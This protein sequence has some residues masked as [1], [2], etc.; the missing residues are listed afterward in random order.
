MSIFAFSS[1]FL[2]RLLMVMVPLSIVMIAAGL[3]LGWERASVENG[4]VE[5]T[6]LVVLAVSL[7]AGVVA[8]RNSAHL[9]RM[10]MAGWVALMVLLIQ[11]EIDFSMLG[12]ESWLYTLRDWDIRLSYWVPIMAFLTVWALRFVPEIARAALALRWRHLWPM[13]LA[14][15]LIL[16]SVQ[17][18][19]AIKSG[20][21]REYWDLL[22]FGEELFELNTYC[23]IAGIAIAIVARLRRPVS[24]EQAEARNRL[25]PSA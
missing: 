14:G 23:V 21:Y 20:G 6:Q 19:N 24:P 22:T 25:S 9:L 2:L 11:R 15:V 5:N 13:L 4:V 12:R 18:E 17:M 16:I 3:V 10:V 7:V 8:A 1:T